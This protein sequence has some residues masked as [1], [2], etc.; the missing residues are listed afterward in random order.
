MLLT[1]L[2]E[3]FDAKK[4]S[5]IAKIEFRENFCRKVVQ[6]HLNHSN[7]LQFPKL[8]ELLILPRNPYMTWN[9]MGAER[10]GN[11]GILAQE[12]VINEP[13][14]GPSLGCDL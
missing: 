7:T 9:E 2:Q 12:M 1:S 13:T 5:K 6:L 3:I 8:P 14:G 10:N 4:F 11:S